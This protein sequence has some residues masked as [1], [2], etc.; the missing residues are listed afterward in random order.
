QLIAR[1][2]H[3]L[4]ERPIASGLWIA[5]TRHAAACVRSKLLA[6]DASGHYCTGF[7]SPAIY[8]FHQFVHV[9]LAHAEQPQ[10]FIG[11]LLKRQ[12]IGRILE[13][14]VADDRLPFF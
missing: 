8:T 2:R 14:A 12:L 3:A 13:S 10:R 5:P 1:Y 4:A 9:M 7:F 11:K 6:S